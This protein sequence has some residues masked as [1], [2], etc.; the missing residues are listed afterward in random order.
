MR[1]DANQRNINHPRDLSTG[2]QH[3]DYFDLVVVSLNSNHT[4]EHLLS[5]LNADADMVSVGSGCIPLQH[6][7]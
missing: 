7:Q 5:K 3:A 6:C 4:H 1:I 2:A